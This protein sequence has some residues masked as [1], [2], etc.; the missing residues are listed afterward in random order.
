MF[1]VREI[2]SGIVRYSVVSVAKW[3]RQVYFAFPSSRA[4]IFPSGRGKATFSPTWRKS[5]NFGVLV[6]QMLRCLRC[7]LCVHDF[8]K[9]CSIHNWTACHFARQEDEKLSTV[10]QFG[11]MSPAKSDVISNAAPMENANLAKLLNRWL[12]RH[13]CLKCGQIGTFQKRARVPA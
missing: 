10:R 5:L 7:L 4:V 12:C 13:C 3:K 6:S 1:L 11:A 9:Q 8:Y 2:I